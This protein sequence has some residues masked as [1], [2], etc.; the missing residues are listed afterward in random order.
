[1]ALIPIL[2]IQQFE[3]EES[4]A[5]FYSN[6]LRLHLRKNKD[7]VTIP[8]RH[9][10][11]L[12]VVFSEG[13]GVHEIDFTSYPVRPGSVFF[14]KPGQTHFW[15][16]NSEPQ[17]F[18]FFHTEEFF[19]VG[20][21]NA[22]LRQ[23]PFYYSIE[24]PPH[25]QLKSRELRHILARFQEINAEYHQHFSYKKERLAS[26][27]RLIYI[28][29]TRCY[30][31]FE[32]HEIVK[33]TTYLDTLGRLEAAI[34]KNYRNEKSAKFYANQLHIT[35][36][37]LNRITKST[38]NKTTT[39]LISERILLEAKRL[40]VHSNNSLA[41][42]AEILGFEDYAYFSRVFKAKTKT[43]PLSFRKKYKRKEFS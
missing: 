9:D 15:K 39:E 18:I 42:I 16:F 37:H 6:D 23:F 41:K 36:K 10:F 17:G 32:A 33:S 12:C 2:N 7:L 40:I 22:K 28:D 31:T 30:T 34:E 4:T 1:M 14:L 3:A 35:K 38:L 21:S 24:N 5:D 8:H 29:L 43:T 13:S 25:L 27:T 19:E 20:F 11:F 26:L